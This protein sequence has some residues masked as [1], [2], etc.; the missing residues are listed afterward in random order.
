MIDFT[1]KN[2]SCFFLLGDLIIFLNSCKN[3]FL[4]LFVPD[5]FSDDSFDE[6]SENFLTVKRATDAERDLDLSSEFL[7]FFPDP[8][9]DASFESEIDDDLNLEISF[10]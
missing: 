10:F 7:N 6:S 4:L 3:I 5:K 8:F 1:L 2:I 9:L